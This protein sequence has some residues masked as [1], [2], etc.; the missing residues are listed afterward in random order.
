MQSWAVA[1]MWPRHSRGSNHS[2]WPL[3]SQE[4]W[5]PLLWPTFQEGWTINSSTSVNI[6]CWKIEAVWRIYGGSRDVAVESIINVIC[7]KWFL[8]AV[9]TYTTG[10][11]RAR[12]KLIVAQNFPNNTRCLDPS[13]NDNIIRRG[14]N[15]ITT[16]CSVPTRG[17]RTK[18]SMKLPDWIFLTNL[19]EWRSAAG[20]RKEGGF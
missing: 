20:E 16:H 18:I 6:E 15:H 9:S 10:V 3:S 1:K 4:T 19:R 5:R 2:L 8:M 13:D 7:C 12:T 14:H 11:R 17:L